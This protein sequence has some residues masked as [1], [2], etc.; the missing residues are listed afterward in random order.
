MK[1]LIQ[2]FLIF[3]HEYKIVSLAIAFVMG[4]AAT[5]LVN[6]FVNDVFMPL[7]SPLIGTSGSWRGAVLR[8]GHIQVMYGN[9]IGQLV[10]FVVIAAVIFLVVKYFFAER[11]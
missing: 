1:K 2:E 5:G 7:I 10:N 9:F 3:L 4:T 6:S 8:M 11:K